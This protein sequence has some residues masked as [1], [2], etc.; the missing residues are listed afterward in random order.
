MIAHYRAANP[1]DKVFGDGPIPD[2]PDDP[3]SYLYLV[4]VNKFVKIGWSADV[5]SRVAT[6][7]TAS[8]YPVELIAVFE[9][10]NSTAAE[11]EA[12]AHKKLGRYRRR[13]E[14]FALKAERA[15]SELKKLFCPLPE[16]RSRSVYINEKYPR[17]H[18]LIEQFLATPTEYPKSAF[19]KFR[20]SRRSNPHPPYSDRVGGES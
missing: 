6:F 5:R 20:D 19:E 18:P 16:D 9:F 1:C 3:K 14:W 7:Q 15:E 17:R 10:V 12:Y 2:D 4:A 11:A 13:G 8:P